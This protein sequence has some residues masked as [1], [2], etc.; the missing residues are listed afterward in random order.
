[1]QRCGRGLTFDN[2]G[3]VCVPND[4]ECPV[5]GV[6]VA[7]LTKTL[8][9]SL[10]WEAVGTFPEGTHVLY[11]RREQIDEL[12]LVD[13][14]TQLTNYAY[15]DYT[16]G[17]GYQ[18]DENSRGPCYID[19]V[20]GVRQT[21]TKSNSKIDPSD[22]ILWD[23]Q[24]SFPGTCKKVDSRYILFDRLSLASVLLDN[25][26]YSV[27][28]CAQFAPIY[29]VDDPAYNSATDP[30]Y[31]N[32]GVACESTGTAGTCVRDGT[33]PDP[34]FCSVGDSICDQ[35]LNQNVCG[36]YVQAMRVVAADNDGNSFGMYRRSEIF[37]LD[38]C[39][40]TKDD[41]Y[42]TADMLK[43]AVG[44]QL[45]GVILSYAFGLTLG[46][47]Y[48]IVYQ[49]MMGKQPIPLISN[50]DVFVHLIKMAP[51]IATIS[52]VGRVSL[53]NELTIPF[54]F[55]FFLW[56]VSLINLLL[57]FIVCFSPSTVHQIDYVYKLAGD[58][59]C[60]DTVTNSTFDYLG[61]VL[62][63]IYNSSL[64]NILLEA[65]L[66]LVSS[67]FFTLHSFLFSLSLPC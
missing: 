34:Q 26:P 60:S 47:F 43:A 59:A 41:I 38:S 48:P 23:Y 16:N 4:E 14:S 25:A 3:A 30:D 22:T 2:G 66:A 29:M 13:L 56:A 50:T 42:G 63:G 62:P 55:V 11:I 20:Q 28:E 36:Q 32:N 5:T 65:A 58:G 18:S 24:F 7:P 33:D 21:L 9:P 40:V 6:L 54:A 27:P 52:F 37:W 17:E 57:Y 35:V 61:T 45:A 67:F 39:E 15:Q 10:H 51:L 1:L 64:A 44:A 53:M 8:A 46:F 49:L 31:V 19:R 12:P